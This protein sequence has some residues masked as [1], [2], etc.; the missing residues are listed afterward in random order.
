MDDRGVREQV[1]RVEEALEAIESLPAGPRE[2]ALDAV[3]KLVELY[4]E[5][6][7]RALSHLEELRPGGSAALA[8]DELVG[9]LLMIHGLH[10]EGVEARVR[11]ALREVE[12]TVNSDGLGLELLELRAGVARLRMEGNGQAPREGLR[13]LVRKVVL[14]AAPELERIELESPPAGNGG[15]PALVQLRRADREEA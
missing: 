12:T 2:T 10:P 1:V 15:G 9:H 3:S 6:W 4:G 14:D 13:D 5:G 11:S 8:A 7:A